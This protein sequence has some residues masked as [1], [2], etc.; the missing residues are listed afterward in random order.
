MK[1]ILGRDLVGAALRF[2]EQKKAADPNPTTF[3]NSD[4]FIELSIAILP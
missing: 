1:R 2:D 3:K 4:R